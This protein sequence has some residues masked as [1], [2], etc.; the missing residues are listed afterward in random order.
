MRPQTRVIYNKMEVRG[1]L[2]RQTALPH[3]PWLSRAVDSPEFEEWTRS[4]FQFV[5]AH[6]MEQNVAHRAMAYFVVY[7]SKCREGVDWGAMA[8][9][10]VAAVWVAVK[11]TRDFRTPATKFLTSSRLVAPVTPFHV[12]CLT[13]AEL[14]VC[15][16]TEFR[17]HR[18]T[19]V[20]F[21]HAMCN[22]LQ[23][24]H[25]VRRRCIHAL[26]GAVYGSFVFLDPVTQALVAMCQVDARM[27]KLL[28]NT[29]V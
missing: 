17:L 27:E 8:W 9:Q 25:T 19:P 7:M 12:H 21:V 1:L 23:A 22:T 15:R 13:E 29:W 16:A 28:N 26:G 14:D 18:P 11:A 6:D 3:S 20:D 4:V 10:R 24:D 5:D 2:Q